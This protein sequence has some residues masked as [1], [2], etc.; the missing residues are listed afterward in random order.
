MRH[1]ARSFTWLLL[2][3]ALALRIEHRYAY[4]N[5]FLDTEVQA[6]AAWQLMQG[7][8]LVTPQVAADLS[9]TDYVPL[10]V[11]MPGYAQALRPW[12]WLTRD[13]Y[14][15]I[16]AL[17][18]LSLVLV[19]GAMPV[20]LRQLTGTWH[21]RAARWLYVFLALS[22]APL[23]YLTSSGLWSL[24]WLMVAWVSWLLAE[25][26]PAWRR[27]AWS[28][29]ALGCCL[30]AAWSRSAYLPLV[31]LPLALW[32]W[33]RRWNWR[34][35]L[36]LA[37][38]TALGLWLVLH[39]SPVLGAYAATQGPSWYPAHLLRVEPFALKA[40]VYYGL[41]HEAALQAR[42][43][44]L[45]GLGKAAAHL[46]SLT[47]WLLALRGAWLT[48]HNP[49]RWAFHGLWL[50]SGAAVLATLAYQSLRHPPESWN[51][52]GFW[53]YL[54]EPRYYAPLMLGLLLWLFV[55]ADQAPRDGWRN[56]LRL[57]LLAATLAAYSY[58]LWLKL[59]LHLLDDPQGTFLADPVPRWTRQAQAIADTASL[60]L[61]VVY[62]GPGRAA[63]M[64]GVPMLSP[65]RWDSLRR[66]SPAHPVYVLQ[67]PPTDSDALPRLQRWPAPDAPPPMAP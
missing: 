39:D 22:P 27:G 17:D 53:T 18:V 5:V 38:A 32:G 64:V 44:A 42:A 66:V 1:S 7:R 33:S 41:P 13:P 26:Q 40:F 30:L 59:R 47:L 65:A 56:A 9:Q 48:R 37:L 11:F 29:L 19:F 45:Y 24:S 54:M 31:G 52:I 14:W 63:E 43:P 67:W 49:T 28:L 23:H 57:W 46:L 6:A 3:L 61:R 55:W 35:G 62:G 21:S 60:P 8:G 15:A 4:R 2:L 10:R 58:P 25:E 12:L 16:L 20:L 51:E 50:L 34:E 36:L